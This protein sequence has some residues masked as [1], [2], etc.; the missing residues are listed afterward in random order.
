MATSNCNKEE[1]ACG[2]CDEFKCPLCGGG[3][4]E[5]ISIRK[6]NNIIGPGYHSE[7]KVYL[8]KCVNCHITLS[9]SY[10]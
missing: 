4:F 6:D 1:C 8:L 3:E 10:E 9:P 7:V 5:D 2:K